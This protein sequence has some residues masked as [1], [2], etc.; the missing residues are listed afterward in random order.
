MDYKLVP[1]NA[2]LIPG[3]AELERKCFSRPWSEDALR[4]ELENE[5]AHFVAAVD[6]T[7]RVIGYAGLQCILDEGYIDNVAVDPDFRRQGVAGALL[8]EFLR[9]GGEQLAF[10]TL[11]VRSSNAP[12]I[13][14]YQK[15]GFVQAGLRRNYYDAPREDALIMT[16]EFDHGTEPA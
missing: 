1:M 9:L 8:E 16:K 2:G 11:E 15:Y 6:E 4:G 7:G 5:N 10:L 14:L 13:A 12:A 3:I